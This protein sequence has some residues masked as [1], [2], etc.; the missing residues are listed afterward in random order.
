VSLAFYALLGPLPWVVILLG[1]FAGRRRMARLV[2]GEP[3]PMPEVPPSVLIV[4]PAKDE[5]GH[6]AATLQS[7]LGLDYPNFRAI[8]VNDRSAD[9]TGQIIREV[10]ATDDRLDAL[11]ID[12]LPPGWLGK[13]HALHAATRGADAD[14]LLFVDSDVL[15]EPGALRDALSV[16]LLRGWGALSLFSRLRPQS[17]VERWLVPVC[18]A[19]WAGMFLVSRTNED[20]HTNNAAANGQFIL[21]RRDLYEQVGGHAEVRGRITEDVALMRNLKKTGE[22]VRFLLGG[23]LVST[24]MHATWP[25]VVRGWARIYTG[26][27]GNRIGRIV[28]ALWLAVGIFVAV[29]LLFAGSWWPWWAGLHLILAGAWFGFA[30]ASAGVAWMTPLFPATAGAMVLILLNALRQARRGTVDWRGSAVR[31]TAG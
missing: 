22:K 4:V 12:H 8:A 24:Q 3:R 10:A 5:A 27:S 21:V 26:S 30:Y 14:W 18:A 29:P 7:V 6:V 13:C 23:H 19:T 15:L 20:R 16:T 28:T 1:S 31:E 11:D 25:Q 9:D 2:P 17:F